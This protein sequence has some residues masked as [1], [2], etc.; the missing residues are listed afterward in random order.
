MDGG[1][2]DTPASLLRRCRRFAAMRAADDF[3]RWPPGV[4]LPDTAA[5]LAAPTG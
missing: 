2:W 3:R 5:L 4:R 1:T